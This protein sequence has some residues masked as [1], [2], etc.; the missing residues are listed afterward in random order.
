MIPSFLIDK[1]DGVHGDDL[2]QF[3]EALESGVM[4]KEWE[5][6]LQIRLQDFHEVFDVVM[7]LDG[8]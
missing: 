8:S 4:A 7:R 6:E 5:R 3:I 2:D 1:P